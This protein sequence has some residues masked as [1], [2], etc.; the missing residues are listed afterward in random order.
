[1]SSLPKIFPSGFKMDPVID[2]ETVLPGG[3]AD[4]SS[5][6]NERHE[7]SISVKCKRIKEGEWE[8]SF[9]ANQ[10]TSHQPRDIDVNVTG[11]FTKCHGNYNIEIRGFVKDMHQEGNVTEHLQE[12]MLNGLTLKRSSKSAVITNNGRSLRI[13]KTYKYGSGITNRPLK[14]DETFTVQF[15]KV[16]GTEDWGPAIGVTE[17]THDGQDLIDHLCDY[18]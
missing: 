13:K 8:T 9:L 12:R 16:E 2:G 1:M 11:K 3:D 4:C 6:S 5:D 18:K 7:I 17:L 10:N 14:D 15:D